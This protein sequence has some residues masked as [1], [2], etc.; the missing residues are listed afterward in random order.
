MTS[1]RWLYWLSLLLIGLPVLFVMGAVHERITGTEP[2]AIVRW[3][4]WGAAFA[5][6][7]VVRFVA[8]VLWDALELNARRR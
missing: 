8:H 4:Y 3:L 2:G 7:A 6:A 1:R 5:A